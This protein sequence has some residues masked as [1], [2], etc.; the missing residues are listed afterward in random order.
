LAARVG[1]DAVLNWADIVF[2]DSKESGKLQFNDC[3]AIG[4]ASEGNYQLALARQLPGFSSGAELG[5][6][7]CILSEE[8]RHLSPLS[9]YCNNKIKWEV[10][11]MLLEKS[12]TEDGVVSAIFEN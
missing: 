9:I 11:F 3:L 6:L 12:A 8:V 1:G 10:E 4:Y 2:K 7:N 5:L